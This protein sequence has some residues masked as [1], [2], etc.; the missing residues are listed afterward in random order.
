[1]IPASEF[2]PF[3]AKVPIV[4]DAFI[5]YSRA[6]DAPIAKA[7]RDELHRFI[8]PWYKMR[9]LRIFLDQAS[10]SAN[11]G[12]W[13]SIREALDSSRCFILLA[14]PEA[15]VSPWP[16]REIEHWLAGHPVDDLL[17]VLT[18]GTLEWAGDGF[19]MARS[20][21]LPAV[22]RDVYPQEPRWVDLTWERSRDGLHMRDPRFG[23]AVAELAAPLHGRPKED[24]TGEDVRQHR[25]TR[26]LVVA[27]AVALAVLAASASA[28][29]V[30]ATRNADEANRRF[31]AAES[32]RLAALALTDR[33]GRM[34]AALVLAAEAWRTA[35]TV[36]AR[37]SLL[38]V[39]HEAMRGIVAFPRIRPGD[40]VPFSLGTV[41]VAPGGRVVAASHYAEA[42]SAGAPL[43]GRIYVW[44]EGRPFARVLRG[45]PEEIS[46]VRQL[47]FG[48]DGRFL[49][50]A[51]Q[52]GDVRVW[53]LTTGAARTLAAF[54]SDAMRPM[55]VSADHRRV[56]AQAG[57]GRVVFADLLTGEPAGERA[58]TL[59]GIAPDGRHAF[60]KDRAEYPV[61]WDMTSERSVRLQYRGPY[62]NAG[63]SPDGR[64]VL[65]ATGGDAD[66]LSV[67]DART[68]EPRW[69]ARPSK[70]SRIVAMTARPVPASGTAAGKGAPLAEG[71]GLREGAGLEDSADLGGGADLGDGA[72][73]GDGAGLGRSVEGSASAGLSEIT[74]GS[75]ER[76]P[77]KSGRGGGVKGGP[78]G[79]I[80]AVWTADGRIGAYR[81][82]D[83]RRTR[84]SARM[85]VPDIPDPRPVLRFSPQGAVLA[86]GVAAGR[87]A[88]KLSLLDARTGKTLAQARADGAAFSADDRTAVWWGSD[89]AAAVATATGA[90]GAKQSL[91][92]VHASAVSP[93][94]RLL[95]LVSSQESTTE[96]TLWDLT[97]D[98]PRPHPLPGS[99]DGLEALGFSD[100]GR[101][102]VAVGGRGAAVVWDT[103]T[104]L[105]PA[106]VATIP[107]AADTLPRIVPAPDG[108]RA[109][110]PGP[111]ASVAL[112]DLRTGRDAKLLDLPAEQ[113]LDGFVFSPDGRYL[114][115][116]TGGEHLLWSMA[117]G[118][119]AGRLPATGEA[120]FSGDGRVLGV[121]DEDPA[122]GRTTVVAR[123]VPGLAETGRVVLSDYAQPEGLTSTRL[124]AQWTLNH[125]GDRLA[126]TLTPG[127]YAEREVANGR[128]ILGCDQR[129]VVN[130]TG[131]GQPVYAPGERE[132][133]VPGDDDVLRFLDLRACG[134][135]RTLRTGSGD[136]AFS[137]D[138]A[139]LA[140]GEPLRL[141][142]V[143]TLEPLGEP[144]LDTLQGGLQF[145][146]RGSLLAADPQGTLREWPL[147]PEALARRACVLAARGL[148]REEWERYRP[149]GD[150]TGRCPA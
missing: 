56:A 113:T 102:L 5:S 98:R 32:G 106:R 112:R 81:A 71:A 86:A 42:G 17:L 100:D 16:S 12:L 139:L 48:P 31:L 7:L 20:N 30:V 6:K 65:L 116:T 145:T 147:A 114:L 94:G 142:D 19:D 111:G 25:L 144:L 109:A 90:V 92:L 9:A 80:V 136:L 24:L 34:D 124:K 97:E 149:P 28:A 55:A 125:A 46:E 21:A 127:Q 95:A 120:R 54:S 110:H 122:T 70:G 52:D 10:L 49:A 108:T 37:G 79:A 22:L 96:V 123:R 44:T 140:G 132:L 133:A 15:A 39:T 87:N 26:R 74:G 62:E 35:H 107:F 36:Q 117:E 38:S 126:E 76:D 82:S 75:R 11:P 1:M 23:D 150:H 60:G 148:T 105:R 63:L 67:F 68:G 77:G 93:D 8:R 40:P 85:T 118:R 41:A 69:S 128:R 141:W 2:P 58:G 61:L 47:A 131:S 27:V 13:P 129:A 104:A 50:A 53:D 99:L 51:G 143:A 138:G 135:R 137:P 43:D 18:D 14:S 57:A 130:S 72:G 3:P 84:L 83:G 4:Y 59:F 64:L 91:D 146:T 134:T 121:A 115:V 101:R 89:E 103:E 45:P 33:A 73:H 66:R 29:A 119:I 88:Q 78:E